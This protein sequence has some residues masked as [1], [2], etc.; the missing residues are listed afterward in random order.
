MWILT[1]RLV[2]IMSTAAHLT[3]YAIQYQSYRPCWLRDSL[4]R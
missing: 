2:R 3:K 4:A 1:S